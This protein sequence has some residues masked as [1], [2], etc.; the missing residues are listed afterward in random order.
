M[1]TAADQVVVQAPA[2]PTIEEAAA[3]V[4]GTD[5]TASTV[6]TATAA[7]VVEPEAKV[8]D[9]Q[10]VRIGAR[11]AAAVRAERKA[12]AER[13]ELKAEREKADARQAEL[14]AREKRIR[15]VEEDPIKFFEEFKS[16]PKAFLEKLAGEHKPEAV[17]SKEVAAL[18]AEVE[19]LKTQAKTREDAEKAASARAQVNQAWSE[20][21]TAF[22]EHVQTD[23]EKYPHLCEEFT[24][25]EATELAY[26][27]LTEVVGRTADGKP[28]T[29]CEAYRAQHGVY[30][31]DEVIAEYL[32]TVAKQRIEGRTKSAWR[33]QGD[34]ASQPSKGAP[35]GDPK[36]VPPAKGTIP[37]TLTAREASTRAAAPKPW[38]QEAAD[39]ESIRIIEAGLKKS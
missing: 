1:T 5:A 14:D 38:T 29:R 28:V 35:T 12:T 20:A 10:A 13:N 6:D 39:E 26:A 23:P 31:D 17:A 32:D 4:F 7:E 16:D 36:P 34:P 37:R 25:A 11:V 3:E 9:P 15:I 21:S 8:E 18:K 33:K 19:T 30:P 24:E 27:Q 2:G 22:I